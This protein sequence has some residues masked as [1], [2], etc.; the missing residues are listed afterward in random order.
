MKI[1][2]LYHAYVNAGMT[3]AFCAAAEPVYC[4]EGPPREQARNM[5]WSEFWSLRRR[6]RAREFDL[7]I[8]YAPQEGL[9]STHRSVLANAFRTLKG[10][11]T[12][13]PAYALR[14]LLPAIQASG[15]RLVLYDYDDLTIIPPLRWPFLEACHLYFK[16]H[17][18]LN[19][20]KSFLLQTRRDGSLWNVLR[21]PRY[22]AW[23]KKIRP[24]SYGTDFQEDYVDCL[25]TEKKYDVF[26]SGGTYYS[27]VRQE[28]LRVLKELQQ[29][30]LRVCLPE[31]EPHRD[32]LRH[33][34]E[35]WLVLSPEGAEWD[36]A[37]HYESLLMKS[38]PLINYPTVRRHQPLL[39]GV[40]ALF[41][42]PEDGL[43][44]P[45]IHQALADKDRLRRIADA[46]REHVLRHHLHTRLVEHIIALSTAPA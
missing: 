25:A 7:I 13:F 14:F 27:P 32:F 44:A 2:F 6:I 23:T 41:Y 30:G 10:V 8:A 3:I 17:P 5:T 24:I 18:S 22:T 36:S 37:R 35:S 45:I 31:H 12:H 15:T 42:P 21:N 26:F 11:L 39:D 33:C 1:L 20:H 29:Q 38:V 9:W 16:L 19:L 46:G 4:Q 28:G 43:L 40:H 34:S